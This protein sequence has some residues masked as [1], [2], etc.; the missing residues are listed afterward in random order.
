MRRISLAVILATL[1]TASAGRAAE[2]VLEDSTITYHVSHPL[3]EVEGVSRA[4]KGKGVCKNKKCDFLVAAPV[5]SFDSGDSNRDL[6]MMQ[7]TKAGE[8]PMIAVRSSVP[9]NLEG[10]AFS[11]DMEIQFVGQKAVYKE[12][13]FTR[14]DDGPLTHL[15]ATI[16][17][18]LTDFKIE[19]PSLLGMP[20][21]DVTPVRVD[22]TWRRKDAAA[23]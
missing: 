10:A 3:H 11:V 20:I 1:G 22:M 6:H 19:R 7:V 16:P 15:S 5:K 12:V 9:E 17:L 4:A 18:V 23:K 14:T 21:K 8:F 2:W 13:K